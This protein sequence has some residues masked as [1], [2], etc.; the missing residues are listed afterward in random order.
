MRTT[1]APWPQTERVALARRNRGKMASAYASRGNA[2]AHASAYED[3][4][5]DYEFAGELAQGL[6]PVVV[7]LEIAK[8]S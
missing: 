6:R 8:S 3:A 7:T 1:S 2:K 4:R 5:A